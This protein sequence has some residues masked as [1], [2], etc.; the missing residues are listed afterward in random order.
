MLNAEAGRTELPRVPRPD[1]AGKARRPAIR[2]AAQCGMKIKIAAKVD[3]AD[4]EYY[5]RR[6]RR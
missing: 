5:E 6:S 1:I 2:I 3:S 4:R